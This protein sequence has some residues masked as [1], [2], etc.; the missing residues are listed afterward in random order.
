[1]ALL[2][3]S[4]VTSAITTLIG[5][6]LAGTTYSAVQV[7]P[8]PPDKLSQNGL[9]FYLYHA[10][11]NAAFKNLPSPGGD[12]PPV[13]YTSLALN[14]YYQMTAHYFRPQN[15]GALDEQNMMGL[16][17]K[18]LHENP[19]LD[20]GPGPDGSPNHIRISLQPIPYHEAAHYWTAGTQPIKFAAYY[21]VT[22]VLLQPKRITTMTGR[23]LSY[24]NFVFP[25]GM[26]RITGTSNI[27]T[28]MLP[29]TTTPQQLN[30]EPAQVAP[31]GTMNINGSNWT[32]DSVGL[33]VYGDNWTGPLAVDSTWKPVSSALNQLTVTIPQFVTIQGATVYLVPGSYRVQVIVTRTI[34]DSTGQTRVMTTVSN[35]FPFTVTP[36]ISNVAVAA[37]V[38]TITVSQ[39][40][41]APVPP[42]PPVVP[43]VDVF[44]GPN[45]MNA[46]GPGPSTYSVTAPNIIT[47]TLPASAVSGTTYLLRIMINGA[48][49]A[50][51]WL[52]VP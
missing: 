39:F 3:I 4:E 49:S 32:G 52:V 51:Y 22:V 2:D 44:L 8:E 20:L 5:S 23:V 31:G 38:A 28:F 25:D 1:M 43:E 12:K 9:A 46:V 35:Q 34:V 10:Q 36:L 21:E 13:A 27:V 29:G 17:M 30:I 19:V 48:E 16:A 6:A 40:V 11:E 47:L 7:L 24:G 33:Q 45:R 26:P 15:I 42:P 37:G 14:L 50:P 18:A 41:P